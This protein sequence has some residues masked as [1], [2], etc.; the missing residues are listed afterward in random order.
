MYD[1]LVHPWKRIADL[2]IGLV[3]VAVGDNYLHPSTPPH[4]D[5]VHEVFRLVF[6]FLW[7]FMFMMIICHLVKYY[8]YR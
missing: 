8:G 3:L 7:M 4:C 6:A 5:A 2:Y 1:D